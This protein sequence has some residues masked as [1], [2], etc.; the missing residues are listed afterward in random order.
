MNS[1]F[2]ALPAGRGKNRVGLLFF[3]FLFLL[4]ILLPGVVPAAPPGVTA[5]YRQAAGTRLTV[6]IDIGSPSP[7]SL[8]LVQRLPA[9]VR[10]LN[11]V[12][13]ANTVN[14]GTGEV[15]WLLHTVSAGSLI[16]EMTLDRT[17]EADEVSAEIRFKQPGGGEMTILPVAKP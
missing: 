6:E 5:S 16:I 13:E 17:V 7:S 14:T 2:C 8:I 12:P 4:A 3:R 15:K 1:P 11:A 9:G 10:L